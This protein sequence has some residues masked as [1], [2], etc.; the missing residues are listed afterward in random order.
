MGKANPRQPLVDGPTTTTTWGHARR[1]GVFLIRLRRQPF[2]VTFLSFPKPMNVGRADLP[3]RDISPALK[4][5]PA[6]EVQKPIFF[7]ICW[8]IQMRA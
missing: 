6:L 3:R 7:F 4:A 5:R 8:S 1:S 2:P